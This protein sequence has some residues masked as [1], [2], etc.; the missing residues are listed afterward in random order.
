MP[1][2]SALWLQAS[3]G[4]HMVVVVHLVSLAVAFLLLTVLHVV[5]GELVPKS[6]SLQRAGRVALT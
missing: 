2:C 3:P 1:R 6:L 5:L 4:R